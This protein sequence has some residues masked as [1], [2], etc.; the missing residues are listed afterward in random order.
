MTYNFSGTV[1][2]T[3]GAC[4]VKHG[5]YTVGPGIRA[6]DGFAA[7]TVPTND[8]V[9]ELWNGA[10]LARSGRHAVLARAVPLPAGGRHHRGRLHHQGLRLPDGGGWAAPRTYSGTLKPT[11][12]PLPRRTSHGGRR[13]R[14]PRRCTPCRA[15]RGATRA[16]TRARRS[17][18]GPLRAATS[19]SATSPHAAR[20][21]T[22]SRRTIRPSRHAATTPSAATSWTNNQSPSAPQYMPT[23]TAATTP[24][25]GPTTGSPDCAADGRTPGAGWDDCAATINLFVAHNRMHDFAY[26]L[27]FTEQNWNAQDFNFGLTEKWQENDP[28][29]GTSSRARRRPR[30]TTRT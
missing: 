27:G 1:P 28:W 25:R 4:D 30:V 15:T 2:A 10:T 14:R 21:T 22:T 5:P 23:S 6:L 13:S 9:L 29:S 7:A 12:R 26:F 3:E 8:V 17:A 19:S 20:G 24:S 16:P 18:G 11:T